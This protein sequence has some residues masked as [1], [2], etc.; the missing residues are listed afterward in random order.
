MHPKII[1]RILLIYSSA[2]FC[3]YP[4]S[5]KAYHFRLELNL[6]VWVSILKNWGLLC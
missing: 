5:E 3:V 1:I 4:P 6:L 2:R